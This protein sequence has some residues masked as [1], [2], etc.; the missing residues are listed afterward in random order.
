MR[1]RIKICG[2]TRERDFA[3][4]VEAGVDAVGLVFHTGSRRRVTARQAAAVLAGKPPFVSAVALCMDAGRDQVR[5]I[6]D[7]VSVDYLQFHGAETE[8]FCCSFGLPYLKA[9][10]MGSLEDLNAYTRAYA[11]TASGFVLDSH[12]V[13]QQGGTGRV[14]DWSK[15]DAGSA[16]PLII[17]GGLTPYNVGD[18]IRRLR[19]FGVDVSSGVEAEKGVKESRLVQAFVNAVQEADREFE[20]A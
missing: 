3:C 12:H 18:G 17:A 7:C 1:T 8:D 9:A 4:A 11:A 13:N 14:F 2:I 20:N 10:A 15:V 19:P 16:L 6:I 5:R